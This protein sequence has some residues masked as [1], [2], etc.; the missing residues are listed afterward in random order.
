MSA[1]PQVGVVQYH[2]VGFDGVIND[3]PRVGRLCLLMR[4][5]PA[6]AQKLSDA[7]GRGF[8]FR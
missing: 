1:K 5:A 7:P 4:L 8:F 3:A 2:E 6:Q